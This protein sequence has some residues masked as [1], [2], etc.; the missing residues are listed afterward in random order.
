MLTYIKTA[1]IFFVKIFLELVQDCFVVICEIGFIEKCEE[2]VTRTI[3]V[4]QQNVTDYKLETEK[5]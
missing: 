3:T 4:L 1:T 5:R 2:S